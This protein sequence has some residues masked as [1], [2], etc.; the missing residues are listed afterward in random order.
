MVSWDKPTSREVIESASKQLIAESHATNTSW[1]SMENLNLVN[2]A[3]MVGYQIALAKTLGT[4]VN[5]MGQLLQNEVGDL[6]AE[7]FDQ[8]T[9]EG[10]INYKTESVEE[11]IARVFRELGIARD[12]KVERLEDAEK[13]GRKL[14]RYKVELYDSFF[15]P[16]HKVLASR[17]LKEYPLSPEALLAAALLRKKLR[18][19]HADARV[20]VTAI[21]PHSENEPLTLIVEEILPLQK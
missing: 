19:K 20:K 21:L 1:R 11:I 9:K 10:A 5:S 7:I 14:V 17:G 8:V 16:V 4:G 3:L 2:M 18:L 15:K 12:V 13:Y 6:I